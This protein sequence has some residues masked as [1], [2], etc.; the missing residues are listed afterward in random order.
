MRVKRLEN[1]LSKK[2]LEDLGLFRL[3]ERRLG[4]GDG[5]LILSFKQLSRTGTRLLHSFSRQDRIKGYKTQ[6]I[7]SPLSNKSW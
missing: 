4:D 6:G 7:R 1:L 2:G 3:E 5:D